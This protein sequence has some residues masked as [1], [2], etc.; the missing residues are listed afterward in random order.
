VPEAV[1]VDGAPKWINA[2]FTADHYDTL[3]EAK[4]ARE[5]L[6][7]HNLVTYYECK[8]R[9]W[10]WTDLGQPPR[11]PCVPLEVGQTEDDDDDEEYDT[12]DED[13]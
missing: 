13:D 10:H 12:T 7:P 11:R 6:E 5:T 3:E 4:A 8:H 2:E 1:R 9:G